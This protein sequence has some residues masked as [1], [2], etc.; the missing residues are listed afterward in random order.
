MQVEDAA[1]TLG[2]THDATREME[3]RWCDFERDSGA[4]CDKRE[5]SLARTEWSLQGD[6]SITCVDRAS[7]PVD[8][9]ARSAA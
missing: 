2:V 3:N 4:E 7:W 5:R 6:S 1:N 8:A 9:E